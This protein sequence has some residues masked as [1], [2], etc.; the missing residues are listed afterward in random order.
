MH[1]APSVILFTVLSGAGFGYLT[2]LGLGDAATGWTAFFQFAFAYALAAGGL[3]ASTFHL[4]NPQRALRAFSQWRTSWLSREAWAS[5]AALALM[6][7]FGAAAVFLGARPATLGLSGALL[8]LSTV[9][10]TSMIYAQLRTVPRWNSPLTPLLFLATALAGGAILAG[11]TELATALLLGLAALQLLAWFAGDGRFAARGH[12]L[13]SATGLG[14]LGRL[15]LFEGPHTGTNYLL[16]EFVHEIGRRHAL[17]L[18]G[19]A[20]L[21]MCL[22]PAALLIVL[23]TSLAVLAAAFAS[24]L[25]GTFVARWLFFAE[26]EHVVRLYYG[27]S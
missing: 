18:R 4:G 3:V 11:R 17:K 5:V 20:L 19:I 9:L 22:A 27:R 2:F 12:S 14:G 1:A 13:A 15:R 21:F 10:A 24:H 7:L 16:N 25:A 6:G 8:A 26:A 23:P